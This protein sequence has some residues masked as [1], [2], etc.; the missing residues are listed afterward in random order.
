MIEDG[1]IADGDANCGWDRREEAEG[2]VADAVQSREGF[3]YSREIEG[4]IERG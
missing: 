1:G 3:N 2:F 4:R